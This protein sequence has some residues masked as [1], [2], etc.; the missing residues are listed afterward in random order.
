MYERKQKHMRE[1]GEKDLLAMA[2]GSDPHTADAGVVEQEQESPYHRAVEGS[3]NPANDQPNGDNR[4]LQNLPSLGGV[5]G[6]REVGGGRSGGREVEGARPEDR[7]GARSDCG[8]CKRNFWTTLLQAVV[9]VS[10]II[11]AAF[12]LSSFQQED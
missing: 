12:G 1:E 8:S 11:L 3:S 7:S 2:A 10:T 6:G 9:K 4:N 5:G